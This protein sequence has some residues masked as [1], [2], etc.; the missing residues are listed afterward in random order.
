MKIFGGALRMRGGGKNCSLVV[1]QNLEP[2][3]DIGRNVLIAR[4]LITKAKAKID[5]GHFAEAH[6][7]LRHATQ[8]QIAAAR[9]AGEA[10]ERARS[11]ADVFLLGAAHST[12]AEGDV[13]L[14]EL[15][16]GLAAQL[17]GEAAAYVPEGQPD[18]RLKYMDRQADTLLRQGDVARLSGWRER[19]SG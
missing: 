10:R 12:A 5:A 16:Y 1:F 18:E 4:E 13:A 6:E 14:T 8:T 15:R 2:C 7:L 19:R 17:F 9:E 11:T 3:S